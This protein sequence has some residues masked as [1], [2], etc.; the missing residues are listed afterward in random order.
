MSLWLSETIVTSTRT[1]PTSYD[2]FTDKLGTH[3]RLWLQY[4]SQSCT[5]NK[6]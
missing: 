1:A 3:T 5:P 6:W 4:H 2:M